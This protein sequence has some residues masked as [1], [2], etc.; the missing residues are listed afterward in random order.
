MLSIQAI[1]VANEKSPP[2]LRPFLVTRQPAAARGKQ[3]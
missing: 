2:R 3:A 1:P